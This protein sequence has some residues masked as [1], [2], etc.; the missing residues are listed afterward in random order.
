MTI[1]EIQKWERDFS[2]RKGVAQDYEKSLKIATLKLS[3][4]VGEV[5]KAI[6]EKNWQEVSTEVCDVIVFACKV[7]NV[8]EDF[9]GVEP[10]EKVI[11]EKMDYCE[12]RTYNK[13][14]S[15]MN[16]P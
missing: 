5:C 12:T 10:L 9:H 8:M 15:K 16:K 4:E 11:E 14:N 2:K 7:A 6:L 1:S 3:E 13:A